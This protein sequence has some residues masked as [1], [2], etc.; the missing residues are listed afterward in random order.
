MPFSFIER[1]TSAS[2]LQ[3]KQT[4]VDCDFCEGTVE[5]HWRC[6]FCRTNLCR[7][8]KLIHQTRSAFKDHDVTPRKPFTTESFRRIH[9]F[10]LDNKNMTDVSCI[11]Y[12]NSSETW[13]QRGKQLVLINRNGDVMK[14]LAFDFFLHG[15]A[16]SGKNEIFLCDVGGKTVWKLLQCG[17]VVP[18]INTAPNAPWGICLN[19]KEEIVLCLKSSVAI[20][21]P[22]GKN[23][24]LEMKPEDEKG[25]TSF[26]WSYIVV[27]NGN[28]DYCVLDWTSGSVLAYDTAF[29][30]KW[31]YKTE[32][33]LENSSTIDI[34]CDKFDNI[35]VAYYNGCLEIL[36][37][38]GKFV[39]RIQSSDG[40][41]MQFISADDSGVLW[42]WQQGSGSVVLFTL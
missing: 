6:I 11:R 22:D 13:F 36:D 19:T 28:L 10:S 16:F 4:P 39:S 3:F 9:S 18:F 37:S 7:K 12:L 8:C 29:T 20:Y 32:Q 21:S 15:F 24:I 27:Q 38:N 5:V 33:K 17:D 31:R 41:A 26:M 1:L 30:F 14:T 23:K 34:S 35:I 42:N 25:E 40:C 2:T